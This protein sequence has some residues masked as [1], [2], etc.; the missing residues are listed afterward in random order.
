[1]EKLRIALRPEEYE[2]LIRLA[3]RERRSIP[4]QAEHLIVDGLR[5]QNLLPV[6]QHD[7]EHLE[8]AVPHAR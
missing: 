6:S 3:E 1:M 2:A 7:R 4:Y 5:S 8:L